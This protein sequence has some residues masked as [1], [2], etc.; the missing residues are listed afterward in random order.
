M[1]QQVPIADFVDNLFVLWREILGIPEKEAGPVWVLDRNTGWAQTLAAVS[2]AE[3]SRPIAPGGT[4]VAAQTAHAAYYLEGFEA[5]IENRHEGS[6]WPGSFRPAT[7]DDAEWARQ[8]ARLFAVAER[9]GALMRGN[10]QW[11]REQLGGAM[12]SLTHLA[13]HLGAVRQ[14]LR[15]VKD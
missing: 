14:M 3:A 8:K 4:S 1:S 5:I 7:V 13:Y 12:A 2:A 6:D 9:V 15:V 11:R 10:P